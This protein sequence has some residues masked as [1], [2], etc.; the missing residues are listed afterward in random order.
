MEKLL[1]KAKRF[2]VLSDVLCAKCD[3]GNDLNDWHSEKIIKEKDAI[4]YRC[5]KCGWWD[6]FS[7]DVIKE[8]I[9]D[10]R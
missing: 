10:S 1:N 5:E 4:R 8:S 7:F 3:H 6:V 9:R 2:R